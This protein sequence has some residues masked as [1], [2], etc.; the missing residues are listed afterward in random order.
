MWQLEILRKRLTPTD[1]ATF[2]VDYDAISANTLGALA[3]SVSVYNRD[4]AQI[5]AIR[6]LR[7]GGAIRHIDI[8]D[9]AVRLGA[10]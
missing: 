1:G 7:H 6:R 2:S 3:H 5:V 10:V 4:T 9:I 8:L